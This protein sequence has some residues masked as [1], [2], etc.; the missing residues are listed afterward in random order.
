ME[1]VEKCIVCGSSNFEPF[2]KCKDFTVSH[3]TFEIQKCSSCGFRFTSPRPSSTEIGPYYK[4]EDYISHSNT[5]T[6]LIHKMYHWVRSYTL[7]KKLQLVMTHSVKQGTILD[8]GC[9]TGAFLSVCKQNKWNV[10][11]MEPDPDAREIAKETNG[12]SSAS[13]IQ[14]FDQQF[15]G[16]RFDAIT[17]WHVLEHVHDLEELFAFFNQRL[18]EKGA[19]I[20]AVPNCSSYDAKKYGEFWAAYDVPRHL[21]HFTPKDMK[22][23]FEGR[24]YKQMKVLPMIFDAFYVSMLS[25]KYKRGKI[26]YLNAFFTGLRSNL[27]ANKTGLEFSSQIYVFKKK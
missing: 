17:M 20:I 11:G 8:F 9:G 16:E 3:E 25:E 26:S 18:K 13:S 1:T 7:I 15:P 5:K 27:K 4:S 14:D 12:I 22:T 10:F 23:L 21:Y 6:G 24:G 19:L 2:I